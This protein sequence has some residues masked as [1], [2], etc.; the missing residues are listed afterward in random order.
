MPEFLFLLFLTGLLCVLLF[1]RKQEKPDRPAAKRKR[2]ARTA[3]KPL[4]IIDGSNLLYWKDNALSLDPVRDA[5]HMLKAS[6]YTPCV[7]FDANAGYLVEDR[8]VDGPGFARRLGLSRRQ[9]HVVPKGRPADPFILG[10]ARDSSGIVVSRDRFRDWAEDFPAETGP[11]RVVRGGYRDGRLQL[12][13]DRV[14][15]T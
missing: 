6:G 10:L 3:H 14:R 7:I 13:L 4:A 2:P 5:I 8:Y 11:D 12:N 15:K 1:L 9:A